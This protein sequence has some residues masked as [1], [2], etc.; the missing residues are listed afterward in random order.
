MSTTLESGGG[1]D[2]IKGGGEGRSEMSAADYMKDGKVI[3]LFKNT[4]NAPALKQKKFKMQATSSFRSVVEVL[5]KQLKFSPT[6]PLFLFIN[7]TFQPNL[8]ET[9][10][11]LFKCFQTNGRLDINYATTAA[12]G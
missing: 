5:Q 3:I 9:L 1:E 2:E 7:S 4:G 6:D 10:S 11:E 12:W 8:D